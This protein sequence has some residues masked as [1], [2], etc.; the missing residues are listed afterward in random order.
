MSAINPAHYLLATG[1]M[2]VGFFAI[3]PREARQSN[4]MLGVLATAFPPAVGKFSLS[5]LIG[6]KR[7]SALAFLPPPLQPLPHP[8]SL[9][10]AMLALT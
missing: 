10:V 5:S 7:Q 3:N 4:I 1:T 2:L 6:H 8:G 9:Y